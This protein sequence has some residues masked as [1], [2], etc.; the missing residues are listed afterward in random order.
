MLPT[1]K[2]S[3]KEL[4]QKKLSRTLQRLDHVVSLEGMNY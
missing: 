3:G 2:L 4:S 1:R